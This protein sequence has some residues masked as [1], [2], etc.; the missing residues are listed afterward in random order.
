MPINAYPERRAETS[1]EK[2]ASAMQAGRP[3]Q[4]ENLLREFIFIFFDRLRLIRF[5]FC[6]VV[7]LSLAAALLMP[8]VYRATAKFSLSIPQSIDP[9]QQESQNDYRNKAT[10]FLRDQKELILSNRVLEK[11]V[12]KFYD[13]KSVNVSRV[14]EQIR[15]NLVVTPPKGETYEGSNIFYVSYEDSSPGRSADITDAIAQSYLATYGEVTRERSEYSYSFFMNQTG[16]LKEEMAQKEKDLR[17]FETNKAGALLEILNLGSSSD[18]KEV[19][20]NSLL[21][22][23]T[24]KYQGLQAELAALRKTIAGIEKEMQ[25]NRIPVVLP[26]MEVQGRSL[27]MLKNKVAQLQMELNEMKSRFTDDYELVQQTQKT[28]N[29]NIGLLRDEMQRSSRAKKIAAES[30]QAQMQELE[31]IIGQLK[32]TIQQ[33]A[34][35]KSS[36]EHLKQEFAIARDAYTHSK[37]QLEQARLSQSLSQEKQNITLVD[38]PMP[39]AK[40]YSPNRPLIIA[41]GIFAG[42]FLAIGTALTVDHF[43][44]TIKKPQDIEYYLE[45]PFLGSLPGA[46]RDKIAG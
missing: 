12:A 8:P 33:T 1:G 5:V 32:D 28:L 2:A 34:T 11:V 13:G 18:S 27:T 42:L 29:M 30:V 14:I 10:R 15:Q 41:L 31:T 45:T 39:P 22:Q 17:D 26:E 19:G 4:V 40:P 36:Y 23:A 46:A 44:H 35:E 24:Q 21:T 43:D 9:L 7:L 38:K 20:P 3:G 6:A 37:N 16:K 25:D